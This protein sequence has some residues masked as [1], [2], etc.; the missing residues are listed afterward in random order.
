MLL[1]TELTMNTCINIIYCSL[2]FNTMY[3]SVSDVGL[4]LS[5]LKLRMQYSR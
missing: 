4:G 2:L 5:P 1:N 3:C